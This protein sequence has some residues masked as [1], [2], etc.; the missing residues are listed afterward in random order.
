MLAE[1]TA[2]L[3]HSDSAAAWTAAKAAI[4]S[5]EQ[6]IDLTAEEIR[7]DLPPMVC[8]GTIIAINRSINGD[9]ETG[10]ATKLR[11]A[12]ARRISSE[13]GQP[14]SMDEVAVTS[15]SKHALFNAAMVLLNPRDEVLIPIP[16]W[17]SF[18]ARVLM[19]GGVPIF[20]ETRDT[21]YVPKPSDL[22]A[23]VTSK[24]KAIVVSTPN[25]PTG[26]IYDREILTEIAQ[27]A[28][29]RDLWI[30]FDE[31]YGAF[32]H[33]PHT[34]HSIVSAAAEA[35]HR[36]LIAN[37]LSKSL[38]LTGWQIGYL[39]GPK[40]V[41]DA[42]LALQRDTGCTPDVTSQHALL[43]HLESSDDVFQ[44]K[45]QRQ[46]SEARTLGLSI[47]STLKSI[48]QPSA[49]GGFYFY[50]DIKGLRQSTKGPRPEFN[51]DD[52]VNVLLNAGVAAASGTIFSDPDGVRLSYGIDLGSLDKGLR[53]LSV[54]LNTWN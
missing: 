52:V 51:A 50:L 25:N 36:T 5:G 33:A 31:S 40:S 28:A 32:A 8:E 29:E 3:K 11:E 53:R 9:T 44:Q 43:H 26:T 46:V 34:H 14:W 23:A 1:R 17:T 24:T 45:L 22:A 20:I 41:I 16:H 37:S 6:I 2:L 18:P 4:V 48:P 19:A 27:L 35:R 7:S 47:L 10:A 39:A 13:T 42:A 54:T 30:V 49:Q 21:K 12:I 38:A 15:G